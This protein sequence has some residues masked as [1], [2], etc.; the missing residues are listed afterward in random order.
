V[1][2]YHLRFYLTEAEH[3]FR[4][5][6]DIEFHII[7]LPKFVKTLADLDSDLDI[8]LYFLRH[9]A[10]IDTDAVPQVLQR[11][12]VLRAL[13]ELKMLAQSK[14]ERERY[15]A[16]RKFQLDYQT[17]M[18]VAREE[19]RQEGHQEGL[20]EGRQQGH[21]QGR[22]QAQIEGRIAIIHLC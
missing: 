1:A 4:F 20:E 15:E 16:R 6:Q 9:A 7:E 2:D 12:M 13:E 10:K 22:L 19:G 11:P 17:G 5:M 18:K 3:G 8:W 21:D 14:V